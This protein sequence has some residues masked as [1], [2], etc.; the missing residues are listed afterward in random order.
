M[1]LMTNRFQP[2]PC[3]VLQKFN[4]RCG[5]YLISLVLH[6]TFVSHGS[7][8]KIHV[9]VAQINWAVFQTKPKLNLIQYYIFYKN[10]GMCYR[11]LNGNLINIHSWISLSLL[12]GFSMYLYLVG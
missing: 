7:L 2:L 6:G 1:K 4:V 11:T 3:K 12:I 10:R 9:T 5:G 8:F